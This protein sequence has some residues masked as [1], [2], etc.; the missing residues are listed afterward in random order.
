[1][2]D[3]VSAVDKFIAEEIESF[4]QYLMRGLQRRIRMMGLVDSEELVKSLAYQTAKNQLELIFSEH[5]RM[6]DGGF[7]RGYHKGKYIGRED[8]AHLLKGR[9]AIKWY[10]P[11]A[12]GATYGTL[13][14]NLQNKYV[15]SLPA[16]LAAQANAE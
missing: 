8:R 15:E 16:M 5:G 4:A 14:A 10:G 3:A 12:Y 2:S 1:M 7:G 6:Q 9:R 13:V 11:F